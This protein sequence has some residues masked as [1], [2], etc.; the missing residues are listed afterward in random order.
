M[1]HENVVMNTNMNRM[2]TDRIRNKSIISRCKVR[3]LE[4]NN[5]MRKF[6]A[7]KENMETREKK[8]LKVTGERKITRSQ[9]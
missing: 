6:N 1:W 8:K 5:V 4:A 2:R 7:A 3:L 9:S